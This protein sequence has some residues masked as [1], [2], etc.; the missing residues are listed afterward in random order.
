MRR[1]FVPLFA[2]S[3]SHLALGQT[4]WRVAEGPR[5][6]TGTYTVPAGSSLTIEAGV[7][8]RI[9]SNSR[10][11]VNGTLNANGTATAPV[12]IVGADNYSALL[13]VSGTLDMKYGDVGAQTQT[14][15]GGPRNGLPERHVPGGGNRPAVPTDREHRHSGSDRQWHCRRPLTQRFHPEHD[16]RGRR[17]RL[18]GHGHALRGGS[19]GR[20]VGGPGKQQFGSGGLGKRCSSGG[21]DFVLVHRLN[22]GG[23][24]EHGGEDLGELL[25]FDKVGLPD[26]Y[27]R[28]ARWSYAEP[29]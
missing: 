15:D 9:S 24:L 23:L 29:E 25:G 16:E 7:T 1:L 20:R 26:G 3:L 18:T 22:P 5:M 13:T 2:A 10:L 28:C 8:V 21:F 17:D 27:S 11:L 4:V 19:G 12:K 6:I 14:M